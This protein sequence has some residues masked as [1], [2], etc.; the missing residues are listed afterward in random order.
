MDDYLDSGETV[1][2]A[3]SRAH[4]VAHVRRKGGLQIGNWM[5]NSSEVLDSLP[6]GA[7]AQRGAELASGK[8]ELARVL[9]VIWSPESDIFTFTT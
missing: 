4:Q 1:E 9:G 8:E 6:P 3:I 5:S 7:V 2:E